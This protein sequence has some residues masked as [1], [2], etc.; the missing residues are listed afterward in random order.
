[1]SSKYASLLIILVLIFSCKE[2]I[3]LNKIEGKRLEIN[4][5]L[6]SDSAMEKYIEPYRKNVNRNLDSVISYAPETY[7]KKDGNLN[8]AIGNLMADAVFSEANPVFNKRTGQ[9]I[10]FVILN[11]GGIPQGL[12]IM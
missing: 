1:M 8:T 5:T 12:H 6:A 10:D 11:H 3:Y 9:N 7:S 2:E 4:E